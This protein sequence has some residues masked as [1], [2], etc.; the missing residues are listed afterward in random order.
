MA[1]VASRPSRSTLVT[2]VVMGK[3]TM[4]EVVVGTTVAIEE[5]EGTPTMG[6]TEVEV[7][8]S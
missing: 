4:A 2:V 5:E 8:V 3:S 6:D 1:E 7:E